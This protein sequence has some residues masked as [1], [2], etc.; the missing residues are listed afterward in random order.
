VWR[1][2]HNLYLLHNDKDA[3]THKR[4]ADRFYEHAYVNVFNYC[5]L[6]S[7]A[8]LEI[9]FNRADFLMEAKMK[10]VKEAYDMLL[11]GFKAEEGSRKARA[12]MVKPPRVVE[13]DPSR[14]VQLLGVLGVWEREAKIKRS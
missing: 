9:S 13:A 5:P 12:S 10:N 2:T 14:L 4:E 8:I 7:H 3:E 6:E 1:S 11:D